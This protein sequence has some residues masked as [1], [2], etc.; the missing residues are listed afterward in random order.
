MSSA[1]PMPMLHPEVLP[2]LHLFT[3][4]QHLFVP[5][6]WP[7]LCARLPCSG[8]PWRPPGRRS[9]R[10]MSACRSSSLSMRRPGSRSCLRSLVSDTR[11]F[12]WRIFGREGELEGSMGFLMCRLTI[13]LSDQK[14]S[15]EPVRLRTNPPPRRV[16]AAIRHPPHAL[17][18]PILENRC[19]CSSDTA[20]DL[21]G[22]PPVAIAF[23]ADIPAL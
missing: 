11:S 16:Y 20:A 18:T 3:I 14:P 8:S 13:F 9:C 5:S 22:S 4:A 2:Q 12:R 7:R 19:Y 10:R 1:I 21:R 6:P 23:D 17:W 15:R